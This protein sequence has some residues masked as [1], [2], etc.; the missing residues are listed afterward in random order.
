MADHACPMRSMVWPVVASA[1]RLS[2]AASICLAWARMCTPAVV[3]VMF[4]LVR[5]SSRTPRTRSSAM[6]LRDTAAC[7]MPSSIAAS[8][9]VPASTIATRQRRCRSSRSITKA[10]SCLDPCILRMHQRGP[11]SS[12]GHLDTRAP[13]RPGRWYG[14]RWKARPAHRHGVDDRQRRVQSVRRGN[15]GAGLPGPWSGRGG[16]G[17]PVGGRG[18][19]ADRRAAAFCLVHAPAVASRA[20]AGAD[21]RHHELVAVPGDRQNWA[22]PGGD[23]GVSWPAVGGA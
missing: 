7:E 18:P 19:A 10:Y 17:T 14:Y 8:V 23:L 12:Y 3:W 6:R 15:R 1:I 5:W 16:R 21:L 9:N 2:A 20:C 13:S 4:L 22:G 11:C